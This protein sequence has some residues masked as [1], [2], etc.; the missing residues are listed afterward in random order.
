MTKQELIEENKALKEEIASLKRIVFGRKS[1]RFV[2]SI[3]SQPSLFD[4]IPQAA[5]QADDSTKQADQVKQNDQARTTNSKSD[6]KGRQLINQ[7]GHLEKQQHIIE[8][9]SLPEDAIY[10]GKKIR[11]TVAYKAAKY[12][13][14][15]QVIHTYKN[16]VSNE[17][18]H[19][20]FPPRA[21]E[22]CEADESLISHLAVSKHVYHLPEHRLIQM[23]KNEGLTV[24][25]STVN[26]WMQKLAN[27]L[28]PLAK[29]IE[30]QILAGGYIQ[31]D[32]STI[33]ILKSK[34]GKSHIGY[35]WVIYSPF[36]QGVCFTAHLS[37][38]HSIPM[39][40]LKHYNGYFQ[41]DGYEAY[42]KVS[43][44]NENATHVMCNAHARRYFEKALEDN[45]A[46]AEKVLKFFWI[47]YEKE[48][49]YREKK[50]TFESKEK[51]YEYRKEKRAESIE[52][53]KRCKAWLDQEALMSY[54]PKSSYKKA[55]TYT[56][57]RW[58]ELTKFLTTGEVEIDNNL[59]ENTIRPLALGRKNYMFAGHPKGAQS[60]ATYQTIFGTCRHLG[61]N[62]ENYLNW[63]LKELPSADLND[64]GRLS[65]WNYKKH[66]LET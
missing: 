50:D 27:L 12:Y 7:H 51:Y 63:Y 28:T 40:W 6:H 18:I 47:F 8:P 9:E 26:G 20:K 21:F 23:M 1:E 15:Q 19:S 43:S 41:S 37:R 34:K 36:L 25:S 53:A 38:A 29:Y 65:P 24:S 62:P 22:K 35:M 11:E 4:S 32:E 5:S 49:R 33:R 39:E 55:L 2:R 44:Y 54:R 14:R 58:K 64:I 57:T 48:R 13:I 46:K 61:I 30:Q 31:I 66:I 17:I 52:L 60:I 59:I 45:R 42:K 3:P 56:L 16:K 10:I